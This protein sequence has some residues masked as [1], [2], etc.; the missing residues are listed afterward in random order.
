[1][2]R[3]FKNKREFMISDI[4]SDACSECEL[5]FDE[6]FCGKLILGTYI[7]DINNGRCT[8]E[9]NKIK[10]GIHKPYI[11]KDNTRI[12]AEG[13]EKAGKEIKTLPLSELY[14]RAVLKEHLNCEKRI[15]R[16]EEIADTLS[17]KIARTTIF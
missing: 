9:L 16:L 7:R 13:F 14:V 3:Y 11:V 17:E 10:D 4:K 8:V 15:E 1:M 2:I 6:P 5:V 12:A